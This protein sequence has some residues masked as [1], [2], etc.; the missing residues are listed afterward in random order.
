MVCRLAVAVP[1]F[2]VLVLATASLATGPCVAAPNLPVES[3]A[4]IMPLAKGDVPRPQVSSAADD[5]RSLTEAM[6]Q[7]SDGWISASGFV[8]DNEGLLVTGD[9]FLGE[10]EPFVVRFANGATDRARAIG[11]DRQKGFAIFRLEKLRPPPVKIGSSRRLQLLDRIVAV[12]VTPPAV[13]TGLVVMEGSVRSTSFLD[14]GDGPDT[15]ELNLL[16]TLGMGGGPLLNGDGEVVGMSAFNFVPRGGASNAGWSM[17]LPI[18][19]LVAVLPEIKEVGY[20]RRGSLGLS[21]QGASGG[22]PGA[23][24]SEIRPGSPASV[25]QLQVGDVVTGFS[26]T[27]VRTSAQLV[28]LIQGTKPGQQALL[29]VIRNGKPLEVRVVAGEA[30]RDR[31]N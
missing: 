23:I 8:I 24:I 9:Y 10:K 6:L 30:P 4:Q 7:R 16:L 13:G 18:E 22:D 12:G 17:N 29:Q 2:P 15:L 3:V 28:R 19:S 21:V 27:R 14:A 11:R 26:G 5:G 1:L 31:E 20:V 25:A